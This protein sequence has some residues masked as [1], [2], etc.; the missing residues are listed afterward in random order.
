MEVLIFL[1]GARGVG[2]TTIGG[3]LAKELGLDFFD[4]D[5]LVTSLAAQSVAEIVAAEGWAGFR[6]RESLALAEVAEGRNRVV[7]TGGGLVLATANR[8][9]MRASGLVFYLAAPVEVLV[10]RLLADPLA[11][12]R[13][14]LIGAS[15]AVE[16]VQMLAEREPFYR[17]AAHHIL[18]A[19][20]APEEIISAIKKLVF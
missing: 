16:A 17:A 8:R 7:A 9:L 19:V 14:S 10:T 20:M 4:T 6:R 11:M 15:P 13:P 3:R 12:Q 1:V 18:N 5:W 2:K